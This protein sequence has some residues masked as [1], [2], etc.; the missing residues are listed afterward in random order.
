MAF[1]PGISLGT[2][3]NIVRWAS[4]FVSTNHPTPSSTASHK[5]SEIPELDTVEESDKT[6]TEGLGDAMDTKANMSDAISYPDGGL[7][8]WLIVLGVCIVDNYVRAS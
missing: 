8:A 6:T 5:M 1:R 4:F 3:I 2:N 7:R